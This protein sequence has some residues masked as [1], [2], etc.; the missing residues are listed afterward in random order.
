MQTFDGSTCPPNDSV[1]SIKLEA[2]CS[3]AMYQHANFGGDA[4]RLQGPGTFNYGAD[5]DNDV[6][7]AIKVRCGGPGAQFCQHGVNGGTCCVLGAG[8]F[9]TNT[10]NGVDCPPNDSITTIQVNAGCQTTVYQHNKSGGT[11]NTLVGPGVFKGHTDFTN[12]NISSME[13]ACVGSLFCDALLADTDCCTPTSKCSLWEGGC[14]TDN[15]CLPGMTCGTSPIANFLG[16]DPNLQICDCTNDC[17]PTNNNWDCCTPDCPCA[18]WEGDCDTDA[19]CR[20]GLTCFANV[21]ALWGGGTSP[22]LDMCY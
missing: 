13:V 8:K 15:D 7:S 11:A 19:D 12:D 14:K 10:L 6:V 1:S 2:G 4:W 3:V 9:N 5:F 21:G 17:T 16:W 20:T 22:S 18:Q